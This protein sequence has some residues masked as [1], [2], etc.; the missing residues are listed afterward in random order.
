M[1]QYCLRDVK[2]TKKTSS[3]VTPERERR[4]QRE[5]EMSSSTKA[6]E[7]IRGSEGEA[8]PPATA[9]GKTEVTRRKMLP[10]Q[11]KEERAGLK[12]SSRESEKGRREVAHS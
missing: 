12:E 8:S 9:R 7:E 6:R 5:R 11:P 2:L 10:P 4:A 1:Q 3:A